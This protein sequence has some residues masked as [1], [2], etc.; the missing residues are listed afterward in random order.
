MKNNT[1]PKALQ[2]LAL[3][4]LALSFYISLSPVSAQT[5]SLHAVQGYVFQL[6]NATQVPSG[7]NVTISASTTGSS[8]TVK[9][10]GPPGRTGFY[11]TT[12]NATDGETITIRARNETHQGTRTTTL[13]AAP[14]VTRV[15]VS[16]DTLIPNE[17]LDLEI[18]SSKILFSNNAPIENTYVQIN[19]TINNSGTSN[20][21]NITIQF[22]NG[23]PSNGGVQIGENQTVLTLTSNNITTLNVTFL[24][25]LGGN[26]VF[27]LVDPPIA[28]NG[29]INETNETNNW[30]NNTL[31]VPSWQEFYGN[32]TS[33]TRLSDSDRDNMSLWSRKPSL[34]GNVFFVDSESQIDWNSLQAIGRNIS[35]QS[36]SNDFSEIDELLS[37]TSFSDSVSNVFTADGST[38]RTTKSFLVYKRIIQN[39]PIVNSTNTTNFLTGILWD[40]FDSSDGEYDKTDKEDLVFVT[41]INQSAQGAHGIY[42][43]EIRIPAG[44]RQYDP[45]DTSRVFI[46]F[47][48]N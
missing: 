37:M 41:E 42:D 27:V 32:L 4:V 36:T 9:T 17:T 18:T 2:L 48:L 21:Y 28:S 12:I 11:S 13:L 25:R 20:A 45:A 44:L 29:T 24:P 23:D 8:I 31:N 22:F 1:K 33:N 6:D 39:V 14:S 46:Y 34:S 7:T 47:G 30:A 5:P 38:P 43:Y 3:L 40:T 26:N 19:A 35:G 10:S 15:N 16:L